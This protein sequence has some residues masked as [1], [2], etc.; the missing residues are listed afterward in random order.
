[1]W[2]IAGAAAGAG[3]QGLPGFAPG[4]GGCPARWTGQTGVTRCPARPACAGRCPPA[5]N[6]HLKNTHAQNT[7]LHAH[8]CAQPEKPTCTKALFFAEV[9]LFKCDGYG[10][11][12]HC[13]CHGRVTA[14]SRQV[15]GNFMAGSLPTAHACAQHSGHCSGAVPVLPRCVALE[16]VSEKWIRHASAGKCARALSRVLKRV[17]WGR[18][19]TRRRGALRLAMA[20]LGATSDY[21]MCGSVR[22]LPAS[23]RCICAQV[24]HTHS[25]CRHGVRPIQ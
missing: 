24:A 15:Q 16:F 9:S 25:I 8:A 20:Q 5:K 11:V 22:A 17:Q 4:H 14:S 2:Q 18:V 7:N 3:L 23:P 13:N 10:G 6:T 1:M 19:Q 21:P 12:A